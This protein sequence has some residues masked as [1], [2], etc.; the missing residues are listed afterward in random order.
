LICFYVHGVFTKQPQRIVFCFRFRFRCHFCTFV[1]G[2]PSLWQVSLPSIQR[3]SHVF[4]SPIKPKS[5]QIGLAKCAGVAAYL[6][7]QLTEPPHNSMIPLACLCVWPFIGAGVTRGKNRTHA[8]GRV[9]GIVL[10]DLT[11]S[12]DTH[13]CTRARNPS[14]AR[15]S[16][17]G[18]FT[19]IG[20]VLL[21]PIVFGVRLPRIVFRFRTAHVIGPSFIVGPI[22]SCRRFS[23]YVIL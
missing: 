22:K 17:V 19:T 18:A 7:L 23:I 16:T 4:E 1:V 3:A 15:R 5:A 21:L 6:C 10:A 8:R 20:A 11:R 13:G 9:V 14:V 12:V 2:A